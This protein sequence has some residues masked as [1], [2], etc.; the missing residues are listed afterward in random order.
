MGGGRR[1]SALTSDDE[2][3]DFATVF[4]GLYLFEDAS[5]HKLQ[6]GAK[7]LIGHGNNQCMI[8]LDTDGI[9]APRQ[10][11]AED[12]LPVFNQGAFGAGFLEFVL[13]LQ[14]DQ[15]VVQWSRFA[16]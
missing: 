4:K 16:A 2:I 15:Q 9:A 6:L 5:F 10:A 8:V 3:G 7:G 12:M 14:H 1:E 13:L 11:G